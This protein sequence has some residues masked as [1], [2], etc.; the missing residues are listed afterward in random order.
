V[1]LLGSWRPRIRL[2]ERGRPLVQQ[3]DSIAPWEAAQSAGLNFERVYVGDSYQDKS[4]IMV[5]PAIKP[6]PPK[7]VKSWLSLQT[8][9]N[10][11]FTRIMLENCEVADA[12][13]QAVWLILTDP[14]FSKWKWMLTVETDNVPP[15]D[16]LLQLIEHAELWQREGPYKLDAIGGLYYMKFEGAPPL[17]YGRPEDVP[18]NFKPFNPPPNEVV[19]VNGLGM[20]FTLFSIDMFRH[21]DPPWFKTVQEWI[22]GVGMERHET[23]DLYFFD[24]AA[25]QG[26]HFAVDTNVKVGHLDTGTGI[27]W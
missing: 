5:V 14:E 12:Y 27:V 15:P 9:A 26:H 22:P 3:L 17:C 13:N 4:C 18:K 7:V 21:I 25:R 6:V 19:P 11:K 8:P 20:G 2:F 1:A 24:K 23:Q 10:Q 16:G